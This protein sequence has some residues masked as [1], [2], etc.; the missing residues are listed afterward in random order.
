MCE[1]SE[2]SERQGDVEAKAE[3]ERSESDTA[4]SIFLLRL[5]WV[6]GRAFFIFPQL[7]FISFF[8]LLAFFIGVRPYCCFG[9][10]YFF[11]FLILFS[12]PYALFFLI[13]YFIFPSLFSLLSY[14]FFFLLF[15]TPSLFSLLSSLFFFLSYF[16]SYFLFLILSCFLLFISYFKGLLGFFLRVKL[17]FVLSPN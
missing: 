2:R 15:L 7:L 16:L 14:F 9:H 6:F 17:S 11:L 13:S 1:H 5:D 10:Q 8:N 4:P 3:V 12:L